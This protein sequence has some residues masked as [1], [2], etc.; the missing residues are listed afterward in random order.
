MVL[1]SMDIGCRGF[2]QSRARRVLRGSW[3]CHGH[4]GCLVCLGPWAL[5]WAHLGAT[6]IITAG[7]W[8]WDC[9][10]GLWA[11]SLI[12]NNSDLSAHY[13][14]LWIL[15]YV[16]CGYE[17]SYMGRYEKT[18]MLNALQFG[19]KNINFQ[20]PFQLSKRKASG[21]LLVVK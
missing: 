1:G 10:G 19:Q 3:L 14:L 20:R 15:V 16:G 8:D 2:R 5:F 12:V 6:G 18:G 4:G 7:I 17:Y 13:L 11:L 21:L 9:A